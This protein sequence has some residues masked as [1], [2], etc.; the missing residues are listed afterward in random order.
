MIHDFH[1]KES[2]LLGLQGSGGG[3]GYLVGNSVPFIDPPTI[4]SPSASSEVDING[5]IINSSNPVGE[6]FGT[7][8]Q[9]DWQ[10]AEDSGF[11]TIYDESLANTSNL[12]SYT[13]T[14]Q[15]DGT[16][17]L[18]IRCR[19]RSDEGVESDYSN[20]VQ[21]TGVQMYFWRLDFT[22]NGYKG[23]GGTGGGDDESGSEGGRGGNGSGRFETAAS[24]KNA[25]GTATLSFPYGS[26]G[27][28]SGQGGGGASTAG[29]IGS[30]VVMVAGG[31]GGG[32]GDSNPPGGG[33]G[34]GAGLDGGNGGRNNAN[35]GTAGTG[36]TAGNSGAGSG[37]SGGS[38]GGGGGNGGTNGTGR[39]SGG[40][41][42]GYKV[43]NNTVVGDFTTIS[44]S[45]S[46]GS[47]NGSGNATV[48][49]YRKYKTGSWVQ[50]QSHNSNS[51]VT[52]STLEN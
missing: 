45:G 38:A 27:T 44:I 31:G 9:T 24:T 19:Y 29:K 35:Q 28:G 25:P 11:S 20:T 16:K 51:T 17:T 49:L 6:D 39:G 12:Q 4:T 30:T 3:L 48:T 10:V 33:A 7:H 50:Q 23:G 43:A 41:G 2:P 46:S 26:G 42:G 22:V 37:S 40:G 13:T 5:F 52:L 8:T 15:F 14:A 36:G 47:N 34:G 21:V 1:K 18:Y 32:T